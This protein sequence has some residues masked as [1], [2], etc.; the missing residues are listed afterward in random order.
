[1]RVSVSEAK[2]QLTE[3]LRRAEAGDEILITRHVRMAGQ[4]IPAKETRRENRT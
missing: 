4:I 3:L 2:A 1:M